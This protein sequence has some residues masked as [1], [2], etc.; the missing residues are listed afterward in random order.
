MLACVGLYGVISYAVAQRTHEIGVRMAL[1]AQPGDVL[2]LVLRQGMSLTIA[3]LVIGIAIG[4]VATRVLSDMLFGVTARD[5][6]T[7]IGVPALLL[8]GCFSGLL[9]PGATR[10]A[11]RS[12]GGAAVRE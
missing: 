9:H 7:F 8:A 12:A 1:G 2:R 4:S 5:P 6:L 10:H 11:D 3:G